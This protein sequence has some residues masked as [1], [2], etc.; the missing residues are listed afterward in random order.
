MIRERK[1]SF[2][3]NPSMISLQR[4]REITL[5][6][7]LLLCTTFKKRMDKTNYSRWL[8]MYLAVMCRLQ[9]DAPEVH[10]K[11]LKGNQGISDHLRK[12]AR[13]G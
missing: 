11:F 5:S 9:E 10:H 1:I 13:S 8:P 4:E 2:L 7:L 6:R 3:L 12:L